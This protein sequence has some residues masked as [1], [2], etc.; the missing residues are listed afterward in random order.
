MFKKYSAFIKIIDKC[1]LVFS[2]IMLFFMVIIILTQ[3]FSRYFFSYSFPWV[4]EL[5]RYLMIWSILLLVGN[6]LG[7]REQIKMT[8]FTDFLPK[9]WLDVYRLIFD[10]IFIIYF[11]YLIKHG[12]LLSLLVAS[13]ISPALQLSMFWPYF[14]VPFTGFLALLFVIKNILKD[15]E[16]IFRKTENE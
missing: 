9:K 8:F 12:W 5:S 14:A 13:S 2:Q 7:T 16:V 6:L 1:S 10:F 3:V 15:I 4:E 11:I